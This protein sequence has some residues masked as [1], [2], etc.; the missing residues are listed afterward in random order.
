MLGVIFSAILCGFL[1]VF[2]L[3]RYYGPTGQYAIEQVL[4]QP[5]LIRQLSF[6][7]KDA[8]TGKMGQYVYDHIEYTYY[9]PARSNWKKLNVTP[10]RYELFVKAVSGD[11]SAI[12]PTDEIIDSFTRSRSAILTIW[13]KNTASA[14]LKTF[15]EIAFAP[16]TGLY[17][18]ELRQQEDTQPWAY[19]EHSQIYE[20]V[21]QLFEAS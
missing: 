8:T 21:Q 3:I 12:K 9:D 15:Q 10:E 13:V 4:L 2:L 7:E 17:R 14:A 11:R 6:Q 1:I 16:Q 18:V 5:N 19:F 20:E